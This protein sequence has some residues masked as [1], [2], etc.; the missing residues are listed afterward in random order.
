MIVELQIREHNLAPSL[1]SIPAS[2]DSFEFV[3][4]KKMVFFKNPK[5]EEE[6][7]GL[8]S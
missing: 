8:A 4:R 5:K 7:G 2:S 3:T 6:E 1:R